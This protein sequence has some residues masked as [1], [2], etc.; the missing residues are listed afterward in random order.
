MVALHRAGGGGVGCWVITINY[1]PL[2]CDTLLVTADH[3]FIH[4]CNFK[5]ISNC[6][7]ACLLNTSKS[8]EMKLRQTIEMP[9]FLYKFSLSSFLQ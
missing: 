4:A 5:A 1:L 2:F 9:H 3:N 7:K 6:P 8:Y